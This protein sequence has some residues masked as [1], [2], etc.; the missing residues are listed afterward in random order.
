MDNLY[1]ILNFYCESEIKSFKKSDLFIE[2]ESIV[3]ELN[4]ILI[5]EYGK[6]C[7][8]IKSENIYLSLTVYN[9]NNEII[10]IFDEG[11]LSA[12]TILILVDKRKRFEFFSW[13][14]EDFIES[15]QWIINELKKL[16][17]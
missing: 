13:K 15:I 4:Y 6:E 10:E 1:S 8:N 17:I 16:I 11:C 3:K 9:K 2:L 5:C 14:D 12:A 7:S